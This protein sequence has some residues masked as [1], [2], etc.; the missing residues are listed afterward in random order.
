MI[1]EVIICLISLVTILIGNN[2]TQTYTQ[3]SMNEASNQLEEIKL[4]IK[5]PIDGNI[6]K[7]NIDNFYIEGKVNDIHNYW[8]LKH[9]SLAYFLEHDELE[10]I[11][12]SLTHL[13][14]NIETKEYE[15]AILD[16]DTTIYLLN[17]LEDKTAFKLENIF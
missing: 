13:R 17:H 6:D 3:T 10:K 11:E 12:T 2:V 8:D 15:E 14:S 9:D 1:K 16:I 5:S 7:E 4:N